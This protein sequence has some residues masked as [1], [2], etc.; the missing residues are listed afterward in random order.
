MTIAA[1]LVLL[2]KK[3][4][5]ATLKT[6][7]S[8]ARCPTGLTGVPVPPTAV[9]QELAHVPSNNLPTRVALLALPY[10]K[11]KIVMIS[12]V[13]PEAIPRLTIP[14]LPRAIALLKNVAVTAIVQR[15]QKHSL[16]MSVIQT[17]SV[18]ARM[19]AVIIMTVGTLLGATS[20]VRT[21]AAVPM[22]NAFIV[23]MIRSVVVA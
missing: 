8:T 15:Y 14:R 21:T 20:S 2:Y 3:P 11:V 18:N 12:P 17:L 23:I 7:A 13:M 22:E 16:T 19:S 6:A 1:S 4:M 9:A 5:N 10:K